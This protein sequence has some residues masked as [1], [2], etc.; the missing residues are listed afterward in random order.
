MGVK[1]RWIT[2]LYVLVLKECDFKVFSRLRI[3]NLEGTLLSA[4]NFQI[5]VVLTLFENVLSKPTPCQFFLLELE[6]HGRTRDSFLFNSTHFLK[7]WMFETLLKRYAEVGVKHEHFVEEVDCFWGRARILHP[8]ICFFLRRIRIQVLECFEISHETLVSIIWRA[9]NLEDDRKLIV[10]AK[11][12]TLSL[13]GRIF[14]WRQG[15]ARLAREERLPVHE[16]RC[17]FLHHAEKFSEDAP[18]GPNVNSWSVIFLEKNN[19]G[20]S[21]PSG[22][23]MTRQFAFH[24]SARIFGPHQL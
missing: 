14:G 3:G 1:I 15:K 11:R 4:C 18:Y 7:K 10:G 22:D 5:D 2:F 20:G 16:S 24:I 19:F 13:F 21:I 12:E 6:Y 23:H 17:V 8:Q 9:N